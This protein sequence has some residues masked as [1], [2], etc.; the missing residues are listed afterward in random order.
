MCG[1]RVR[2]GG[3]ARLRSPPPPPAPADF[4][5]RATSS[6][7]GRRRRAPLRPGCRARRVSFPASAPGAFRRAAQRGGIRV[8][9]H[10]GW[11]YNWILNITYVCVWIPLGKWGGGGINRQNGL[12]A[13]FSSVLKVGFSASVS[14]NSSNTGVPGT[15]SWVIWFMLNIRF[16]CKKH[17]Q[18]SS[19]V[20][21]QRLAAASTAATTTKTITHQRID[22]RAVRVDLWAGTRRWRDISLQSR[23]P[24]P[25]PS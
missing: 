15:H 4:L 20:I 22:S 9:R 1:R 5:R 24:P 21:W 13:S 23:S 10:K 16:Y 11:F 25:P 8:M 12:S 19:P 6:A 7:R 18:E 3:G 17:W 14:I 2:S